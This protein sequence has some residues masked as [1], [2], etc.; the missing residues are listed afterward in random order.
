MIGILTVRETV[1]FAAKLSLGP[2]VS[3]KDRMARVNELIE[4]FGLQ[5]QKDTV[6]GTPLRKGIS[7]GQKRRLSVASQ[8]VT[9][10]RILFLDEPTSGLDS[11]SSYEVMNFIRQIAKQY[12]LVVI[13]SIHQPSTTTFELFDQLMLLSEGQT[14]YFGPVSSVNDF[15]DKIHRPIPMHMNPAEYLLDAV[16]SDFGSDP[17]SKH[18]GASGSVQDAWESS[19]E[20]RALAQRCSPASTSEPTTSAAEHITSSN[21]NVPRTSWILLHRNFIKSYRDII[22]YGTRVVMY[23]GLAIL[24]GRPSHSCLRAFHRL[25][26]QTCRWL[27]SG[28]NRLASSLVRSGVHPAIHQRHL[29]R[30]CVHVIHGGRL[31]P[32]HHRGYTKFP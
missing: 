7:G 4:S 6:V 27:T 24:M 1:N 31:C 32:E 17:S 23:L 26:D 15:F 22:A 11:T 21:P 16:N 12:H 2:A 19:E 8:L 20:N 10:P 30:R 25:R 18:G 3:N 14:C 5:R 29:L 9:S 13:A 28:R